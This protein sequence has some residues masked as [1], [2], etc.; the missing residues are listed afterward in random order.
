M[1]HVVLHL[2]DDPPEVG[3]EAPEDPGLVEAAQRLLGILARGQDIEEEAVAA[4]ILPQLLVDQLEVSR[5]GLQRLGMDVEVVVLR[6]LEQLQQLAR[7]LLEGLRA[8]DREAVALD[9]KP[10][11]RTLAAQV[12]QAEP[13]APVVLGL[14]RG[15]EDPRQVADVL[16][17]QE[18]VLHEALDVL[19][20][21][22]RGVAHL[23]RDDLL[24]VEGQAFLA[25]VAGVVQMTAQRPKECLGLFEL[26][27][28]GA[29]EDALFDQT[30]DIVHP[31]DVLGDPEEGVQV[32]Q[33][34]LALLDVG[35][36]DI[37]RGAVLAVTPVALGQL[38]FDE[39]GRVLALHLLLI[40]V[41][42]LAVEF[43]VAPEVAHLKHGGAN[44][45]VGARL[46][47]AVVERAG[48]LP[49]LQV[50]VPQ[51]V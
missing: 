5:D 39:L 17:D 8:L 51:E 50:Q 30:S 7:V 4:R 47:K 3:Q 48:R 21:A 36:E 38:G 13:G 14:Q 9:R 12:Q 33:A 28:L 31:V 25:P 20:P 29:G 41:L 22:A 40:A 10:A 46:A 42:E 32:A 18:V 27:H 37:A 23:L 43:L 44:R 26:A 19:D 45:H 15:A 35:F 24:Q 49:D 34:A 2:R 11:D 6:D 1:V 16:G